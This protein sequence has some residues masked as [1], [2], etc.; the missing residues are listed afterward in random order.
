MK[1]LHH[2]TDI[3]SAAPEQDNYTQIKNVLCSRLDRM[4]RAGLPVNNLLQLG[5]DVGVWLLLLLIK[6]V[7]CIILQHK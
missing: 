2:L 5:G 3:S 1:R 6:L 7:K 4:G